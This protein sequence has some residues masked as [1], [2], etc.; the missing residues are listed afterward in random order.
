MKKIIKI[1]MIIILII[2]VSPYIIASI[3]IKS[4]EKD[5]N[6]V[7]GNCEF[8]DYETNQIYIKYIEEGPGWLVVGK[9]GVLFDKDDVTKKEIIFIVGNFPSEINYDL[10]NNIFVLDG[11]YLGKKTYLN[12]TYGCFNVS[13]FGVLGS[14]KRKSF[15]YLS[16][17]SLTILDYISAQKISHLTLESL[18]DVEE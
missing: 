15:T 1:L 12:K 14:L 16:K 8:V 11:E 9:D 17:S 4:V 10:L 13:D 5:I 7:S 6:T 18:K 2:I 3:P